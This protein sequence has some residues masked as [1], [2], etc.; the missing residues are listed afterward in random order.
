MMKDLTDRKDKEQAKQNVNRMVGVAE[1]GRILGIAK[2]TVYKYVC[3]RQIP[4]YKVGGRLL[5]NTVKLSEWLEQ[6]AVNTINQQTIR[7]RAKTYIG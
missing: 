2:S 4:H 6:Y 7:R 3:S 1:A 5:F